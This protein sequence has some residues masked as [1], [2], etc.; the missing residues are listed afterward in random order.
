MNYRRLG[1]TGLMVSDIGHGL[2]GMGGW[3]GGSDEESERALD[4]SAQLDCN[5]FDTAWAYGQGKCDANLGRLLAR[6]PGRRLIVASKV[7]PRNLK[8]PADPRDRLADTFPQAHVREYV[9]K[10]R[11]ALGGR[12]IDLLQYHVWDDGWLDDPDFAATIGAL[13][14]EGAFRWFGLSLNRWEPWNGIRAVETGLVDVV[15]V[16][17]NIFDQAPEDELF[18]AC[19]KADVGVIAR[20][21]LDEGSLGGA[22]TRASRFPESDWRARYFSPENLEP[23]MDRV[24]RIARDLPAGM[25]LVEAALRFILG[26]D[27]VTT[28]I[29]GMRTAAHVQQNLATSDKGPLPRDLHA[30]LRAYRWDRKVRPGAETTR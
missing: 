1:R 13:K 26:S 10:I 18:P 7:P 19:R 20:V 12:E 2:W 24:E 30:R 21:P 9:G 6:H 23:T 29:V 3:S 22:L 14:R 16:I 4:E 28:T 27:D 15:Q 25:P 11:E 17:Y 8:W 5:F